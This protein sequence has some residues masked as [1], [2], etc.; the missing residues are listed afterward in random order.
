MVRACDNKGVRNVS[1]LARSAVKQFIQTAESDLEQVALAAK[2]LECVI[3]E[4]RQIVSAF[5]PSGNSQSDMS[6]RV[7]AKED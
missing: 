6:Q 3:G 1:E 2:T 5:R 7:D 4:L